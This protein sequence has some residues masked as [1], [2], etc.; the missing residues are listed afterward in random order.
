M[1]FYPLLSE[2]CRAGKAVRIRPGVVAGSAVCTYKRLL[3][4]GRYLDEIVSM[5]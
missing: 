4:S 3:L 5:E 2:G 1:E